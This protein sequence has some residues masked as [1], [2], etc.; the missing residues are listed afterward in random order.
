MARRVT[1]RA[2]IR[3]AGLGLA[4]ALLAQITPARPD[5]PAPPGTRTD[6]T[7]DHYFGQPVADPYR[8]LE[9]TSATETVDWFK[10]QNAYARQV[11]DA[12]PE[13]PHW[14]ARIAALNA[15]DTRVVEA[16]FGGDELFYLKRGPGDEIYKLYVR[17]GVDGDER[18]LVDPATLAGNPVA[19]IDYF[20]PSP[21]GRRIAV[22]VSTGGS[23]N[24]TMHV[25]DVATGAPFGPPVPRARDG[26]PAWRFDSTVLFYHQL[27]EMPADAP[28][29]ETFRDSV[30]RVRVY[31][32]DGSISDSPVLGRG[33]S[34]D[35][36]LDADDSPSVVVSPVSPYAIGVVVHGVE[37]EVS[38]YVAPL[39]QI[40]GAATPWR[41]LAG[42]EAGI[43]DFD[44]RGEWIYVV[45]NQA[46]PRYRVLRWSLMSG[47]G[48]DADAAEVVVAQ[49]D[50]VVTGIGVAKD[51]LYVQQLDAGIGKLLRLE[52]NVNLRKNPGAARTTGTAP[53][54][55]P[56]RRAT[57]PAS[58]PKTAG[59]ARERDV[60]LPYAGAI[61]ERATDPLR[62]GALLR[63]AGWTQAPAYYLVDGRS[64][65]VARTALMP[66]ALADFAGMTS[67]EVR[68]PAN[69]G[70]LVPL[71]IVHRRDA[72][73]N[74]SAPLLIDAYGAY[75]M[76]QEPRFW[77]TL[78]AWLERGGVFAVAHVRGGGELGK[79]WHMAGRKATKANSWHDLIACAE[80]LV[81]E[82]WT[83]PERTAAIGASAGGLVVGNALALRPDLFGAVVSMAG[84]HDALRSEAGA[85]GPANAS[86]FGSVA[87]EDGFRDLLAMSPYAKIS[88]GKA[89]PAALFT[90]GFN[91]L[92]VDPWDPGKMAAR[93]QDANFSPGGSGKPVLLRVDFDAGHGVTSTREQAIEEYTDVFAFLDAQLGNAAVR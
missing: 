41:K 12:L 23:E 73:R 7:V 92:R 29:A 65:V 51:A 36:N 85:A 88:R 6:A 2:R 54:P 60:R 3:F 22:G 53:K 1:H 15:A 90:T 62:T 4:I 18:L 21:N 13:R 80:Y 89:Y 61:Q 31:G 50:R 27:R 56:G 46:A 26:A 11:L 69:D 75:G 70:A 81:R 86:E 55:K 19:A 91:D 17:H 16:Q 84:F 5:P 14:R 72:P 45:S 40:R 34:P 77:P 25:L 38:L 8:W 10:A 48:Y 79:D 47:R 37:R 43:T 66:P 24:S 67:T 44:L 78:L 82:R 32:P 9:A 83:I 76:V 52:F 20:R 35:V 64:G 93:L 59:V 42:P 57:A 68:V 74:G 58:L 87:T 49:S 28:P 30:A 39:S 71:T 33:L 63:L